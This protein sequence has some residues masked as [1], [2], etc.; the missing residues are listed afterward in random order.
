[1][2]SETNA[3]PL[4]ERKFKSTNDPWIDEE[5]LEMI[6]KRKAIFN[7]D[8]RRTE[9]WKKVK[10]KT[11][12]MIRDRKKRYYKWETDKLTVAGAEKIAFKALRNLADAER[13]PTWNT[14]CLAPDKSGAELVEILADYFSAISNKFA[15]LRPE[16]IPATYDREV[17]QIM[18]QQVLSRL[19]EIK[20]TSS[21]VSI[22]PMPKY[23]NKFATSLAK[24]L[25]LILNIMMRNG[26]WPKLWAAEEVTIIPKVHD[27]STLEQCRNVS[28]TSIFT[29]LAETFMLYR[30]QEEIPPDPL[31][32]GGMKGSGTTHLLAEM[33]TNIIETLDDS[34]A[35]ATL[36]S[37][38]LSKAFNH[39]DHSNCVSSLAHYRASNQSLAIA[40]AFLTGR[41]MRIKLNNHTFSS[42][43]QTPGGSPQGTKSG[44]Y[45]FCIAT[46]RLDT[47]L[48]I[49]IPCSDTPLPQPSPQTSPTSS[50]LGGAGWT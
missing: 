20:K 35:A 31:Q 22:D 17:R 48:P 24:P 29:K 40:A 41:K 50:P 27:A 1:M 11:E 39:M 32:F 46:R 42:Y 44:N 18:E 49:E 21:A 7:T 45:F 4:K 3:S 47:P 33:N 26:T 12:S 13:P 9:R 5:T 2:T 28:C 25:T 8:T 19:V 23:I 30:L 36:I 15:A 38:D 16:D 34:R 6:R 43:R 37:L 14:S 10:Q